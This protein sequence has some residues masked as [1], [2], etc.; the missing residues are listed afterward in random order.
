[1]RPPWNQAP[2]MPAAISLAAGIVVYGAV[3]WWGIIWLLGLM[4]LMGLIGPMGKLPW[5]VALAFTLGWTLAW[6]DD[7][8]LPQLPDGEMELRGVVLKV[9]EGESGRSML[10]RGSGMVVHVTT[11]T[12][13][14]PLAIGDSV[15]VKAQLATPDYT[16][17]L[18]DETTLEQYHW[19]NRVVAT[20]Y[21]TPRNLKRIGRDPS[22][23]AKMAEWRSRLVDRLLLSPLGEGTSQML[24]AVLLGD[25]T[26][27]DPDTQPRY[28]AA[29]VAHVLALSGTHV[30][31]LAM[32][33]GTVLLAL[34]GTRGRRWKA[35]VLIALLWIYA[36]L[37]GFSPSVTR[38]VL[39]ASLACGAVV[40]GR[41]NS[42][43]NA[44]C[45]AAIVLLIADPRSLYDAGA[46]LSF[47]A[48]TGLLLFSAWWWRLEIHSRWFRAAGAAVGVP[49]AAMAATALLAVWHFHQLPLYF[50]A[51]NLLIS[52]LL[53]WFIGIGVLALIFDA[54]GGVPGWLATA[55]DWLYQGID[56]A[57]TLVAHV[58]G[59]VVTGLYPSATLLWVIAIV[60]IVLI[61][62]AVDRR[63]GWGFATL[64]AGMAL[65]LTISFEPI[66][67]ADD[68][69]YT[70]ERNHR[71]DI[72]HRHADTL[73]IYTS[74]PPVDL[75]NI[76]HEAR[77]RYQHYLAKRKIKSIIV[78]PTDTTSR[79]ATR[80]VGN[81]AG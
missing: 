6:V 62:W 76:T 68:E 52:L 24:V 13:L 54:A 80:R 18:P 44:L 38:S 27:L 66:V 17:Y 11:T 29:G 40:L 51:S 28:A 10:V 56:Y 12:F 16:T 59:G 75:P 19:R 61:I 65:I 78:A 71:V 42:G 35:V 81:N 3:P 50:L 63:K 34:F 30:G 43:F 15:S 79:A 53:L 9:N 49:L 48:V 74:A 33:A 22:L 20:A 72:I 70:V 36:A 39:M 26:H 25:R 77:F 45:L 73:H 31:V 67:S 4:G 55:T 37:T 46:Q 8:P 21:V 57:A 7:A 69:L 14:P 60:L 41:V 32:I 64:G 47:A 5:V 58:P 2:L 1:M 23:W